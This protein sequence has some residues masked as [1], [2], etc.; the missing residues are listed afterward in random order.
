[1]RS[2]A[3][4]VA[5]AAVLAS[6]GHA[7]AQAPAAAPAAVPKAGR[8]ITPADM[9]KWNALR[10]TVL[11][12]DGKWFA[13]IV[14]PADSDGTIVLR[15][16]A[17]DANEVR[18]PAGNGGGSLAISGDSKWFGYI[19]GPPRSA[20]AVVVVAPRVARPRLTRPARGQPRQ[21]R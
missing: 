5:L 14:G 13:Y 12:N 16:T 6:T 7:A 18:I 3:R 10:Q 8:L 9:R 19:V 4:A 2:T 21:A 1:M 15:G 17:K 11:S 20:A